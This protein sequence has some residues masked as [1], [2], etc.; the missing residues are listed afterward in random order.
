MGGLDGNAVFDSHAYRIH[1]KSCFV[2]P[3]VA[4]ANPTGADD[5][6]S[7]GVRTVLVVCLG[8]YSVAQTRSLT[9][10]YMIQKQ[11]VITKLRILFMTQHHQ[12]TL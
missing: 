10:K 5:R 4:P 6:G 3:Q 8:T 11:N 9:E 2:P 1:V 7:A 12:G